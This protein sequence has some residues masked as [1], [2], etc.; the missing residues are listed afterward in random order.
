MLPQVSA[1]VKSYDGETKW[2]Y[3]FIK[4]GD[5]KLGKNIMKSEIKSAMY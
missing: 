2:M 1:Y 5:K 4:Y 3:F